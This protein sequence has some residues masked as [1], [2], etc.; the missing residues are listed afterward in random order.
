MSSNDFKPYKCKV[1]R[2]REGEGQWRIP[3]CCDNVMTRTMQDNFPTHKLPCLF[4]TLAFDEGAP[5]QTQGECMIERLIKVGVWLQ[6]AYRGGQVE[7]MSKAVL[8]DLG[9]SYRI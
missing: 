6:V 7:E 8:N 4:D 3:P 5:A 1:W 2:R 9:L